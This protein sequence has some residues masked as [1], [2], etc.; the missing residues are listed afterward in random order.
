MSRAD[1]SSAT[2]VV[3]RLARYAKA[4]FPTEEVYGSDGSAALR[5]VTCSGRFDRSSRRYQDNLVVF[6]ALAS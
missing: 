2:F 5:L 3:V 1:G 6:A 4:A